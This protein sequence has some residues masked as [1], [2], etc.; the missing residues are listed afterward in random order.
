MPLALARSRFKLSKSAHSSHE[1]LPEMGCPRVG[2]RLN[3]MKR[4]VRVI[5]GE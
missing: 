3:G 2:E 4:K 5:K 1:L